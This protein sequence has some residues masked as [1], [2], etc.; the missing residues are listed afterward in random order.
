VEFGM[1]LQCE[2][3]AVFDAKRGQGQPFANPLAKD[4]IM[5]CRLIAKTLRIHRR[6]A[7]A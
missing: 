1:Y 3:N 2:S 6:P 5:R 4:L 7:P